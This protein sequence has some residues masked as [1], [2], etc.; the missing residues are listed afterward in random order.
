MKTNIGY[1]ISIL[2]VAHISW[3]QK[4][5]V[6]K[7]KG[8]NA[9]IE[10]SIPLEEGQVYDLQ[11]ASVSEPVNYKTTGL[12]SRQNSWMI[13]GNFLSLRGDDYQKNSGSLQTRYGWNFTQVEF[14]IA[15]EMN[16]IDLGAGATTDFLL[17]GYFDYNLVSNRDP[18]TFIYGPF[19]LAGFGSL[20][21]PAS[22]GG[23]S[24]SIIDTNL[25]GFISWFV[26]G[27]TAALRLEGFYDYQQINST[28]K[29]TAV[30]GIGTRGFVVFY[31]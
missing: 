14:G 4:I 27:G 22:R 11:S 25:G 3:A 26:A 2:L 28:I 23:G 29:T 10:S 19:A 8:R 6:K 12:K 9:L 20:Q 30:T 15:A 13:G 1:L 16:T 18:K 7:T 17:G 24:T 5:T 31:F 21:S